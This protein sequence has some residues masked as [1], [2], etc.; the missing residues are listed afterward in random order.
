MK[1]PLCNSENFTMY[2]LR[3]EYDICNKCDTIILRENERDVVE[4]NKQA[5]LSSTSKTDNMVKMLHSDKMHYDKMF[6][7]FRNN[8]LFDITNIDFNHIHSFG[9]GLP[10][11]ESYLKHNDINVYDLCPEGYS[12]YLSIFSDIYEYDKNINYK[13]YRHDLDNNFYDMLCSLS[14][15]DNKDLFSFIHFLEHLTP[16]NFIRTFQDLAKFKNEFKNKRFII[17]QPCFSKARKNYDWVHFVDQ[18]VVMFP[19]KSFES[20]LRDNGFTSIVSTEYS[21]DLMIMFK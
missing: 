20:F 10:K 8:G 12:Q 5:Y 19:L 11:F 4:F 3:P 2:E 18:H 17:Y 21:D 7:N 6:L 1:C 16:E 9:G 14:N 15:N 13:E